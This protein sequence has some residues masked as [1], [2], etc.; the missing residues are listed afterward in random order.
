MSNDE[1]IKTKCID[2]LLKSGFVE[3]YV[4]KLMFNSD[5][6]R[7]YEDYKQEVFLAICE[8]P[9]E[10][11]YTLYSNSVADGTRDEYYQV[12]NWISMLIRN[13]VKSDSSNAYRKLKKHNIIEKFQTN[14]QW[15]C[16]ENGIAD[17][18]TITDTIKNM[19]E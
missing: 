1:E 9:S 15:K 7:Y 11:Y 13:I 5:I 14:V 8:V 4:K 3:A 2:Y 18:Y 12:R 6:D 10:K 17:D 19:D 16:Y